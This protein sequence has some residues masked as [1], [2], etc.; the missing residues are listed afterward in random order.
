MKNNLER[1]E[2]VADK[3]EE[4]NQ[5]I[6]YVGGAV[7]QCYSS[8]YAVGEIRATEDVDCIVKYDSHMDRIEFEKEL[9][10]HHFV[11]DLEDGVICRWKFEND[12]VDIM[13]T[14]EKFLSFSNKWYEYG[15]E[16]RIPYLLP[17]GNVIFIMPVVVFVATKFEALKARGGND[18]R[19][20]HDFEDIIFILNSCNDF[21]LKLKE[22]DNA[23][24][25]LYI[26]TN[27]KWLLNRFNIHEEI[28]CVL[29]YGEEERSD[30][31][32]LLLNKIIL[33]D[34]L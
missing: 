29:P 6:V 15:F 25:K 14:N 5:R 11:E 20:S 2:S 31:I 30:D 27:V 16:K 24:L 4:L 8:D 1:I 18:L 32:I 33:I 7:V 21:E 17:N 3:F 26:V 23:E 13:P 22:E 19:Y 28:E 10:R 9:R 34:G 12:K